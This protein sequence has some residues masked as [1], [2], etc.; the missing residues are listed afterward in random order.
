MVLQR[1]R[2]KRQEWGQQKSKEGK[3]EMQDFSRER[4]RN[5]EGRSQ[6]SPQGEKGGKK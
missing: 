5:R 4:I 1:A 2:D 6:Q 3:S